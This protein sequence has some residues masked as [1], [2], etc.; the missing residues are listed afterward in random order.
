MPNDTRTV[1]IPPHQ[2]LNI[3]II[4]AVWDHLVRD[5]NKSQAIS[6]EELWNVLQEA[7]RTILKTS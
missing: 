5:Q 7:R 2:N 3:S 1:V 6:K 4:E